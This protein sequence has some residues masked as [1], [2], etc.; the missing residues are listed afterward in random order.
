[1]YLAY[2]GER[3]SSA[4]TGEVRARPEVPAPQVPA[5]VRVVLLAQQPGGDAFEGVDQVYWSCSPLNC[6]S[7]ASK[8]SHISRMISSQREHGVGEAAA[9]VSG[10]EDQ[11]GMEVVDDV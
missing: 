9:P 3:R 7:S 10:E 6:F 1:M 5:H 11:V 2:D 8:S 4:R